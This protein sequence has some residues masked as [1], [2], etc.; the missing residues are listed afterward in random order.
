MKYKAI[1][2]YLV[3]LYYFLSAAPFSTYRDFIDTHEADKSFYVVNPI[4]DLTM[5]RSLK[6]DEIAQVYVT[7]VFNQYPADLEWYPESSE[8]SVAY[9]EVYY[10]DG[11]GELYIEITPDKIK[12]GNPREGVFRVTWKRR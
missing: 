12:Y 5:S 10:V 6:T 4:Y 1:F 2:I 11:S 8:S 7:Q 3:S 9:P